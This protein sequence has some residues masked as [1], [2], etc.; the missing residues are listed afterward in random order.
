MEELTMSVNWIAVI[1]SAVIAFLL[2]WIWYSPKVFGAKWAKGVGIS[3]DDASCSVADQIPPMI[4][5]AIGTFLLAWVVGITAF[6]NALHTLIL[7]TLTIVA[8]V[9]AGG[10]FAKKS[11]N[12]ITVE[13]TYIIAMVIIMVI[14]HAIL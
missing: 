11:A 3:L 4:T 12:A 2:G 7:I 5:Q 10:L 14:T 8:L 9:V 13:A 6:H 1:V